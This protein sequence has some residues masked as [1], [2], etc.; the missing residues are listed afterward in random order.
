MFVVGIATWLGWWPQIVHEP[1]RTQRWVRSVPLALLLVVLPTMIGL[2]I[3]LWHR[4]R[5]I[6]LGQSPRIRLRPAA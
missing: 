5:R 3:L 6:D 2:A 1:L 4:R